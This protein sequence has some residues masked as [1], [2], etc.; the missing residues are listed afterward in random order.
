M[1]SAIRQLAEQVDTTAICDTAKDTR[2]MA[3]AL[4]CRSRNPN[5]CGPAVTVRCRGDFLGVIQAIEWAEPGDVIVVDGGGLQTALAGEL[6]AR[7]ALAKG[8][9][10]I[11]VDGGYRDL[12][13]VRDCD[14][15]IYSRH[16]TPMAGGTQRL[17]ARGE[18]VTC[19]GVR[20]APGD[21]VIADADGVVVLTQDTAEAILT[22]AAQVRAVEARVAARLDQGGSLRDCLNVDE[23][24][25]R[26]RRGEPSS[27]RFT[28]S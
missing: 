16:V 22:A 4:T 15:A 5:M 24:I 2:V 28:V 7:A 17:A 6:F 1:N 3:S 14:L 25:Q 10:G 19:G 18:T 23:H 12:A 13:Y 26:L 8:I 21:L 27:L 9:A 11:I 20:V